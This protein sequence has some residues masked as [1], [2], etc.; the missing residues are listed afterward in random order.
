MNWLFD[1]PSPLK[2][3]TILSTEFG[4]IALVMYVLKKFGMNV[5]EVWLQGMKNAFFTSLAMLAVVGLIS[6]IPILGF[7]S[8]TRNSLAISFGI[9]WSGIFLWFF[10]NLFS[11]RQKAGQVLLDVAPIQ[12]GWLFFVTG[13]IMIILGFSGFADFLGKDTKYS[14]LISVGVGLFS[15][16]YALIMSFSRI[17]IY[18]NGILAYIDLI[19]WSKIEAY[20]WIDDNGKSFTLKLKYKGKMPIILRSGAV[21]VPTDKRA[22]LFSLLK[23]YLSE[24]VEI[25]N[26]T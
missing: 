10:L 13:I 26:H 25:K 12:N 7:S 20:E 3:L 5:R 21:P 16:V 24:D 2:Y 17:Q 11:F 8:S 6:A 19:K 18:E 14:W 4:T 1:L 22:Q 23:Q 9:I 15:G